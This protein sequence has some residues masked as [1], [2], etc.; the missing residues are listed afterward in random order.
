MF[1]NYFFLKRLAKDLDKKIRGLQLLT[2]FSQSKEELIL[3]FGTKNEDFFIKATLEN[4]ISLLHF[5]NDFKRAKKN[6]IDLFQQCI[7]K[8]VLSVVVFDFER[9][10]KINLEGHL[11][12]IFKMHG[13][14]SNILLSKE[15]KVIE[16]LKSG[17]SQD[18]TL[19]P[20][21]L[22]KRQPSKEDFIANNG[23]L[24]KTL[25]ALGKEVNAYLEK[26][27][28]QELND[29]EK[30]KRFI[31]ILHEL[32]N[33]PITILRDTGAP[34][35]SILL[36]LDHQ[37]WQSQNAIEAA[38]YYYILFSQFTYLHDGKNKL[39][40]E[41]N[42]KINKSESYLI[43]TKQKLNEVVNQRSYE[44]IANI[45]MANL[46]NFKKGQL[47]TTLDDFYTEQKIEIELKPSISPQ[48]TAENLY[49][50]SKNRK[51]EIQKLQE[52][53]EA[54]QNELIALEIKREEILSTSDFKNLRTLTVVNKK[55]QKK[56]ENT[57]P[58]HEYEA[59]GYNIF[60]GKHAKAND[61]LTTQ[62]AHKNDLWLHARDVSG[63]HVIV[64]NYTGKTIPSNVLQF[65]A[66]LAAWFSKRKTD[67][68]CPVIYTER[69]YVRKIKGAPAGQVRIDKE[70]VILVEPKNHPN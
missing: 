67:T 44:E 49:R 65:A 33:N 6:S 30:W 7:E 59:F 64:R 70:S 32:E 10:F 56:E 8:E 39:L 17:L 22:H 3:G 66:E 27:G 24:K 62:I 31:K 15:N 14:R 11:S 37:K 68:L 28:Y 26:E 13:S 5:S 29:N 51:I 50:K 57:S 9:S 47:K 16:I 23:D 38:S 60:V 45:I 4:Q 63:S 21:S 55:E 19:D 61:L 53:L 1:H 25:P 20:Q 2:C 36:E 58:Y 48:K 52:N 12:I 42:N 69:K 18:F 43:K 41:I 46:H 54:R 35:L 40:R 34:E